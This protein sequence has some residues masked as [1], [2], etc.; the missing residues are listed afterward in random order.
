M[1]LRFPLNEKM[2]EQVNGLPWGKA[3]EVFRLGLGSLKSMTAIE[4]LLLLQDVQGKAGG[5]LTVVLDEEQVSTLDDMADK[6]GVSRS[7]I[8]RVVV[9]LGL[10]QYNDYGPEEKLV[11]AVMSMEE[12]K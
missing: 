2:T 6:T 10:D 12:E 9:K 8:G 11:L 7:K 1:R 5:A 4:T 3:S